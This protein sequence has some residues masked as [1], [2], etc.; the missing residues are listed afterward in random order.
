MFF[1]SVGGTR[2]AVM[3]RK[4]I[5]NENWGKKNPLEKGRNIEKTLKLPEDR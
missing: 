3:G 1:G 5:D 2:R 4:G